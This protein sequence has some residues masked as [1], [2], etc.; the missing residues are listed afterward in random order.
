MRYF[1]CFLFCFFPS[2]LFA[3]QTSL[4]YFLI[5]HTSARSQALGESLVAIS[6][7][8]ESIRENPAGLAGMAGR[9]AL[10]FTRRPPQQ[11]PLIWP[12]KYARYHFYTVAYR[13]NTK[14]SFAVQ[15]NDADF[16]PLQPLPP[17]RAQNGDRY[18]AKVFGFTWAYR[19][20]DYL[21]LGVT[22]KYIRSTYYNTATSL[23]SDFGLLIKKKNIINNQKMRGTISLGASLNNLGQGIAY[24]DE[25]QKDPLPRHLQ[26]GFAFHFDSGKTHAGLGNPLFGALIAG[27]YQKSLQPKSDKW[28]WGGG[29]ELHFL[30]LVYVRMGYHE[31][32]PKAPGF[33]A[34]DKFFETGWTRGFGVNIPLDK[35]LDSP[36]PVVFR[37]D[38]S[39]FPQGTY[40]ER[41]PM[42]SFV[43]EIR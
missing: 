29:L 5:L 41:Y 43:M 2:M 11:N 7:G 33:L 42:Y 22:G 12:G 26:A 19:V 21:H 16:S 30:Q 39:S 3:Q 32:R 13:R 1:K 25:S 10:R 38:Y 4:D 27:S 24:I 34:E 28:E 17:G 31:V 14:N 40:I 15:F 37:F 20:T 9:W 8:V 36:T 23:A 18:V 6:N 35:L